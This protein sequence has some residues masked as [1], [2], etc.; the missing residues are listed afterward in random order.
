ML[1]LH[2]QLSD[3]KRWR[4]EVHVTLGSVF[5]DLNEQS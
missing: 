4:R 1:G 2:R 5:A 3:W